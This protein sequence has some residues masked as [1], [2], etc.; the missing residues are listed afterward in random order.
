MVGGEERDGPIMGPDGQQ[1][2][3][4]IVP[5]SVQQLPDLFGRVQPSEPQ[6]LVR[7]TVHVVVQAFPGS[8]YRL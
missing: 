2:I 3:H 5:V 1:R 4:R 6:A 8:P 7:R